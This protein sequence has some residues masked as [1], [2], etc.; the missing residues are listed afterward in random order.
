MTADP[1]CLDCDAPPD[2]SDTEPDR[3]A[4]ASDS[5]ATASDP[6]ATAPDPSDTAPDP[7]DDPPAPP[8]LWSARTAPFIA[9]AFL[10]MTFIAVEAFAVTTVLPGAM[11]ELDAQGWYSLAFAAT[12]STSLVGMVVGG[13][14]SDRSGPR[15][16]LGVGGGLFLVGLALCVLAPGA[17]TFIAGRLLQGIGGG[18]VSVVLYV[19]IARIIPAPARPAMFGLLTTAWLVPSMAGPVVAGALAQLLTWRAVFALILG[20][21]GL[22]LLVLLRVARAGGGPADETARSTAII[23]R[24]GRLSLLAA[25]VLVLLHLGAQTGGSRALLLVGAGLVALALVA[26]TLLP[27]GTLRLAGPAQRLVALRA[28]FGVSSAVPDVY[29]TL[30]LQTE[31]GLSPTA[32]GLVLAVGA[33][34]W[35]SGSFVQARRPSTATE[36]RMLILAAAPLVAA[37][38]VGALLLVTGLAPVG[39]VVATALLKGVGMGVASARVATAT[40]DLAPPAEQGGY[41][42]ALQSGEAMAV[43]ASTAVMA[44]VLSVLGAAGTG[45]VGVYVLLTVVAV[46]TLL[47]A[48]RTPRPVVAPVA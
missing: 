12:I 24:T 28:G 15:P 43:A 46:G 3:S 36:H 10:L 2:P 44:V 42:S 4:A 6:P 22:A 11:E 34:G 9:G 21:S 47:V 16:P 13:N 45:F 19:L 48:A 18:I 7:S 39:L 32:A 29:L 14:W 37:A 35:A 25:G 33:L 1:P 23:G 26:R 27:P 30:Y 38:P 5:S 41:S 8:R 17:A 31:R 40:L 20:G